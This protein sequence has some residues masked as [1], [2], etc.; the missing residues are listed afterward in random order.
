MTTQMAREIGEQPAAVSRTLEALL[1]LRGELASLAARRSQVLF[2]ARG[3]SDNAAVYGRYLL[4]AHSGMSAA[5]AAPSIATHYRRERDLS[6]TLVVSLSQSGETVEI[7]AT[8]D[9]AKACGAATV[10]VTND[11]HSR[12]AAGADLPFVTQAGRELAVPA[13][14]SYTAQLAALAVLATALAPE[15]EQLD[16][17]LHRVPQEIARQLDDR[18]G[19]EEAVAALGRSDSILVTGRGLVLGTALELALKLEETC[20]R[21]VRGMSYADLKHGPI[22][23]VG[24]GLV[25]VLVAASG[26]PLLGAM[27]ELAADLA[28]RAATVV[29]FGG[30]EGFRAA[31]DVAV[32]GPELVEA[33]SPLALI[34]AP[35]LTV[36][37]LARRLGL[38]PDAPR[39]LSKVTQTDRSPTPTRG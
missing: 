21:P 12:L 18:A 22:A 38:D 5:L 23:V 37:A 7:V 24:E 14:K 11:A 20:L 8:Q 17:E 16:A 9:W 30:D 35:Q 27:T 19:I 39:G 36:E 34:V 29:G 32:R 31:C 6:N 25:A 3:S 2:V 1:P 26:G 13:T 33:V 28:N 10:A 4:E 15:P